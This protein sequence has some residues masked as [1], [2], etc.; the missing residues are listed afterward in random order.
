MS[1]TL[2]H[3]KTNNP[4]PF[5]NCSAIKSVVFAISGKFGR[6]AFQEWGEEFVLQSSAHTFLSFSR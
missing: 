1:C 4:E 2:F 3:D 6:F 5:A